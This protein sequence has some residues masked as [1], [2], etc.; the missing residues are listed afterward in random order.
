MHVTYQKNY[1]FIG[2]ATENRLVTYFSK[3]E[4]TERRK[5]KRY[6]RKAPT[7]LTMVR[8]K[9]TGLLIVMVITP[10]KRLKITEAFQVN[11]EKDKTEALNEK[12]AV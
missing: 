1:T 12:D 11:E 10:A 8:E 7:D 3:E 2:I 6:Q 5:D 4:N 9:P